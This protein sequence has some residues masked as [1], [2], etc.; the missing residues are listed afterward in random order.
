M[1][2]QQH[3]GIDI[4]NAQSDLEGYLVAAQQGDPTAFEMIW[5][6]LNPRITRFAAVQCYGSTLDYEE[7]VSEAWISV[8]KDI[9][10]FKG[11]FAAF[12]SWVYALT[13]N[14]LID[15]TRKRDRQVKN[16]GD[17]TELNLED[18]APHMED[19]IES[20]EAVKSIVERINQ[21][22][23]SQAEIV[24]LR[25]VADLS[26]QE[27][28]KVVSK[29]ENTVRVLCHRGLATLRENWPSRDGAYE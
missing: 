4:S 23:K 18:S 29:S 2:Y 14:R 9:S 17:V 5:K 19:L 20:D 21:L 13:R 27:T 16:G 24:M 1:G 22:P 28:A 6:N 10:K 26:V 12:R 25:I 11:D 3:E 8:A 7:V 15:G